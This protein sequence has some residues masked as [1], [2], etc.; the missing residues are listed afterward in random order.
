MDAF[1][2]SVLEECNVSELDDRERFWIARLNTITPNGYN[3]LPGGQANKGKTRICID[4]GCL[5]S[6]GAKERCSKCNRKHQE[7]KMSPL[8]V[9]RAVFEEGGFEGAGRK[10]GSSGNALKRWMKRRHLPYH[11]K[12]VIGWYSEQ[13]GLKRPEKKKHG[14]VDDA[15]SKIAQCDLNGIEL[16]VFPSIREAARTLG[17]SDSNIHSALRGSG[18]SHG[19]IWKRV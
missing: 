18:K 10:L 11:T 6:K 17:F 19:F 14:A 2:F 9:A 12:D 1:D 5:I 4:C 3:I 8:D 13:T 16:R 15:K 7:K